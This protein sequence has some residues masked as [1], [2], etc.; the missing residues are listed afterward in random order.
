MKATV[1][2][3]KFPGVDW[4]CDECNDCLTDQPGFLDCYPTW[5]CTKCGCVNYIQDNEIWWNE[6][7]YAKTGEFTILTDDPEYHNKFWDACDRMV[8]AP[9]AEEREQA[10]QERIDLMK[11]SFDLINDFIKNEDKNQ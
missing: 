4:Y 6:S 2:R 8:N 9:T 7:N 10:R 3:N 5:S 1:I 11:E